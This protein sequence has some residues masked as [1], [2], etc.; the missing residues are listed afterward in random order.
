VT[1]DLKGKLPAS[2]LAKELAKIVGGGGGG[3]ADRAQ[4]GGKDPSKIRDVFEAVR[5]R[6]GEVVKN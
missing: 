5:K 4:A 1:E 6:V 2:T 3:R